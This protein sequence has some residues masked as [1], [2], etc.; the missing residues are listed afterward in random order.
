M[1]DKSLFR[2]RFSCRAYLQDPVPRHMID[3]ILEAGRWA[4]NGGNLQPWRFVV[5]LDGEYYDH[6]TPG[7]L[8]I[9][10]QE[11]RSGKLKRSKA[12]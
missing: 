5:V 1:T 11:V 9:L 7:K 3:A 6:M 4:P 10:I 2:R 12:K 8:R